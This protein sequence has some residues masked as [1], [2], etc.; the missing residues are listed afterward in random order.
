MAFGAQMSIGDEGTDDIAEEFRAIR[1]S[2]LWPS[3]QISHQYSV[4]R[5]DSGHAPTDTVREMEAA[6]WASLNYQELLQRRLS[7]LGGAA[8]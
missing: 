8:R 3:W 5:R 7:K 2:L 4:G 1:V 6:D